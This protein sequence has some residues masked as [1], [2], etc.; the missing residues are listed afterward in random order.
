MQ[1]LC[2]AVLLFGAVSCALPGPGRGEGVSSRRPNIV[3][4]LADDMGYGDVGA[5]NARSAISTP[6]LDFHAKLNA[7]HYTKRASDTSQ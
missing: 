3:F 1:K 7:G 6:N 5:L 4:V 2:V